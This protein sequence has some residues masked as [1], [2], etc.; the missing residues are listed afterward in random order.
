MSNFD[1]SLKGALF[2]NDD[3]RTPSHPDYKGSIEDDT[4][5][6]FWASGWVKEIKQGARRGQKFISIA[7]TPKDT[8]QRQ[9]RQTNSQVN[10]DAA[11]FLNQNRERIDQHRPRT[12]P[13]NAPQAPRQAPQ[14]AADFDSFDDDIPF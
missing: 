9:A 3:K 5:R 4:G 11:D 1:N 7:L 2:I 14:P 10:S 13:N 6:E 12:A 8:N